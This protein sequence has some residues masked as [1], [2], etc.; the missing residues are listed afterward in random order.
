MF[1]TR[2]LILSFRTT[3]KSDVEASVAALNAAIANAETAKAYADQKDSELKKDLEGQIGTAKTTLESKIAEAK[4]EVLNS[5]KNVLDTAKTELSTKI[6][7]KADAS[8][9]DK[10]IEDLNTVISNAESVNNAYADE[11]NA[12]PK[13]EL[14]KSISDS[15]V[16]VNAA[17]EAL[18]KRLEAVENET[19]SLT[20]RLSD[21]EKS[22]DLLSQRLSATESKSNTLQPF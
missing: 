14:T 21:A 6:A 2:L 13:A 7:T 1:F 22:S 16:K 5:A 8:E 11:K 19:E 12:A 9:V 18:S 4:T 20:E 10:A 15:I 3:S 17:I